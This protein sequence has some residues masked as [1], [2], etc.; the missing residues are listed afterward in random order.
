LVDEDLEGKV[1]KD[2]AAKLLETTPPDDFRKGSPDI[3][4]LT[5]IND[6]SDLAGMFK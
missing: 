3:H 6:L 2:I 1:R 5:G 4:D